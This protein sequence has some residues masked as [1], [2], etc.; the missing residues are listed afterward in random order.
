MVGSRDAATRGQNNDLTAFASRRSAI[1]GYLVLIDGA[2]SLL[3][4]KPLEC[5]APFIVLRD[6]NFDPQDRPLKRCKLFVRPG[7]P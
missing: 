5:G 6:R 3:F 1:A 7:Q 4:P 2:L